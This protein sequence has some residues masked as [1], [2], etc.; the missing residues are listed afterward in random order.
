MALKPVERVVADSCPGVLRPHIAA[1]GA[2][3]RMRVPGGAVPVSL[4]RGLRAVAAELADGDLGLTS[5]GNMQVRGVAESDLGLA[6][7]RLGALGLLPH[8]THER[9]RN[10]IASPLSGRVVGSI[11]DVDELVPRLDAALCARGDLVALPGRFMIGLDD[12]TGDIAGEEPDVLVLAVGPGRFVLRPAGAAGG[13]AVARGRVVDAVL[14]A[15]T[16]FL[17]ERERQGSKAWRVGELPG[18]AD[19]IVDALVEAGYEWAE[20]PMPGGS[21][22]APGLIGQR[23]GRYAV[24]AVVPLS[25]LGGEQM[26]A[27]AD[28]CDLALL[29][30]AGP[31]G[32]AVPDD[33]ASNDAVLNGAVLNGAV[34]DGSAT[35]L[36][37]TPWRRLLVRD[38]DLPSA[39]VAR[40]LMARAGLVLEPD[41]PWAR[42][43]ACAGRP[44]CAKSLTDVQ[45]DARAFA[46]VCGGSGPLV[47]W[48]GCERACGIPHSGVALLAEVGGY[49]VTGELGDADRD[50]AASMNVVLLE[51][52]TPQ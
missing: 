46:G 6:E 19:A 17:A 8:P 35:P 7:T 9:V 2:L 26:D 47:H 4:L 28:S 34:L 36:R 15:A 37:I 44:G 23:D 51:E 43:T 39:L 29:S 11:D 50:A 42:V 52:T 21:V 13:V 38:L 48:A 20:V 30:G 41:A 16:A 5:R 18:G 10:I 25:I 49:R 22:P 3:V 40:D 24:C 1:D 32:G 31:D 45:A 12:G 27:V 33:A 14:V